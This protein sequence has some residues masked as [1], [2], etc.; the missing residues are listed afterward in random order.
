MKASL[1][2][3][4]IVVV[5]LM[6]MAASAGAQQPVRIPR[7]GVIPVAEMKL[8]APE[9]S[10]FEQGLRDLGYVK[11]KTIAIEYRLPEVGRPGASDTLAAELVRR[12]V[13]VIVVGSGRAALAAKK[14]TTTIPIVIALAPDPVREGLVASLARPGGNITGLSFLSMDLAPKQLELLKTAL[15]NA[16]RIAVLW[17]GDIPAHPLLLKEMESVSRTLGITIQALEVR[18][19]DPPDNAFAEMAAKRAEGLIVLPNAPGFA[20]RTSDLALKHRLPT[21]YAAT[22][23]ADAGGLMAYAAD[24]R[25]NWRRAATYVDKILKG[26]KPGDLPVQQPTRFE[27]VVNLRTARKLGIKLPQA[28]LSRADRV[29]E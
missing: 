24:S 7:I 26:A 25:D 23:H 10:A 20:R 18:S 19:G 6:G 15:P 11:G 4:A 9:I 28:I 1:N 12:G 29:I 21:M 22:A 14:A 3:C 13:D 17:S 16:T 2:I 8:D 5:A 27:F